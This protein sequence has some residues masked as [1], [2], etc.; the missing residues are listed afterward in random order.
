MAIASAVL[1]SCSAAELNARQVA[2]P[3][4]SGLAKLVAASDHILV[5]RMELP[6]SLLAS[7][8]KSAAPQYLSLPLYVQYTIKGGKGDV[9]SLLYFPSNDPHQPSIEAVSDLTGKPAVL[10]L[11]QIDEDP[12]EFYFAGDSPDALRSVDEMR[13]EAVR[14][15]VAR[16]THIADSW[17]TD[18]SLPYFEKVSDLISRLGQVDGTEQQQVFDALVNL[19]PGAVPAI[20][21]LMDD[22]RPLRTRSISLENRS[23][24]AFEATRHYGPVQVVDGLDAVLQQI[25]GASFGTIVNGGSERERDAA[26]AGWK[27]YT[28]DRRC[29]SP[30]ARTK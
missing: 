22:R 16:Q 27:V 26:V 1:G 18:T 9:A 5:G 13:I 28:S 2:C 6:S 17:R 15:E 23:P 30:I 19:G 3:A 29:A 24:D 21:S 20:V 7:A 8:T 12:L 14:D 25:T 4:D 10:F 11:I